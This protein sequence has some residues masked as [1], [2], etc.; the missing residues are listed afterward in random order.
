MRKSYRYIAVA[1]A[2]ATI[3][4][5]AGCSAS[6]GGG[7]AESGTVTLLMADPQENVQPALDAF[8]KAYPDITV[9]YEYVP[10]DQFNNLIEQRVGGGDDSVDVY[11]VDSGAVG[12][13]ASKGYLVDLTDDFADKVASDSLPATADANTFD[14]KLWSVPLWTSLQYLYYNKDLLDAAGVPYPSQN[15]D[16]AATYQQLLED[17]KKVQAAGATW[18]LLFDQINRYYQLQAL[19][20]SAGGGS[21]VTGE[22]LLTADLNNEGW[23]SAMD[24]YSKLFADGVAPKGIATEQM[25]PLFATG[26]AAYIV[27]GPWQIAQNMKEGVNYG[28]AANPIWD[29]GE[30][31]MSTGSW[32]L[33][34]NPAT[35]NLE[36]SKTLVE[37]LGLTHDGNSAAAEVTGTSPTFNASFDEFVSGLDARDGEHTAGLG[38]LSSDQLNNIA[39]NRPNSPGFTQMAD[40]TGRAFEDIRN[41]QDVKTTLDGAQTELQGLW[42]RLK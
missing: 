24:W 28:V 40:V 15:L 7:D 41:A 1:L 11:A 38:A 12:S 25:A 35:D 13:L 37:F 5:T 29:G 32:N 4:A 26:Q 23:A 8:A 31:A 18:G 10:F 6:S 17:S 22:D 14:G 36:A 30:G 39:V 34:I 19:I 9:E 3:A 42:D 27:S 21:G 16:E 33:G 2:A 20:E